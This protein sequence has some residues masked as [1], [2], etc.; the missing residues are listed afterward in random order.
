MNTGNAGFRLVRN[1]RVTSP[2][3]VREAAATVIPQTAVA[4]ARQEI[5]VWPNYRP[6]PLVELPGLAGAHDLSGIW[7]KDEGSRLGVGSFKPLGGGYAVSRIVAR[8]VADHSGRQDVAAAAM[9]TGKYRELSSRITVTCATD[10]NHGRA[11]AWAAKTFGCRAVVYMA[12]VVSPHREQAIRSLGAEVVSV[13][14]NHEE[15]S[16][17]CHAAAQENGWFVVSETENATVP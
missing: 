15:A 1:R 2:Q 3:S 8:F 13:S 14:G 12:K 10:G 5:P 17:V 11:V 6:T 9:L 7:Y 4:R 16:A